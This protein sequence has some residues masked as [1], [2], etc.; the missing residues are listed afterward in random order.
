MSSIKGDMIS[1]S[2]TRAVGVRDLKLFLDY[3][4][5]GV[6][7]LAAAVTVSGLDDFESP[8]EEAVGKAVRDSGYEVHAQVG[9]SGYRIDLAVVH[10]NK[11][12]KYLLG[13]ECDGASY[14]SA[15]CARE[16]D[17]LRQSVL[18]GLGWKL[19]R[20]W[21]TEWWHNPRAELAKVTQKI[22]QCLAEDSDQDESP[23]GLSTLHI[24][25]AEQPDEAIYE[26]LDS[27]IDATVAHFSEWKSSLPALPSEA[28]DKA[29][30]KPIIIKVIEEIT[31]I[32]SPV[33]LAQVTRRI[34]GQFNISRATQRISASVLQLAKKAQIHIDARHQQV[35]FWSTANQLSDFLIFRKHS[36]AC[37]RRPEDICPDEVANAAFAVLKTNISMAEED[38]LRHTAQCFGFSRVGQNVAAAVQDGLNHLYTTGRAESENGKVSLP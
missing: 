32:E 3:A 13:V 26:S 19:H 25:D 31:A 4:E 1:L 27:D 29:S 6:K 20:I 16:R 10:P 36:V 12:G 8:F 30:S 35:F 5:R 23:E 9:C 7:S 18:E 33:S 22:A 17:K 37:K 38:L 2:K 28:F 15:F 11:P 24:E 14:H 21:S 34:C